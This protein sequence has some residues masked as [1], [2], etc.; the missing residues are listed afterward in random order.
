MAVESV[1]KVVGWP[2]LFW[3]ERLPDCLPSQLSPCHPIQVTPKAF[4]VFWPGDLE[5]SQGEVTGDKS[6]PVN[7]L[8]RPLP[9]PLGPH[10]S[11]QRV[12]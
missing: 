1:T 3:S 8:P 7:V 4:Q 5:Q 2:L 11:Y 10:L 6:D 12:G 9:S